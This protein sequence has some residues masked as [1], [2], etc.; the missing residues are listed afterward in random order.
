MIPPIPLVTLD[1]LLVVALL[2]VVRGVAD[3]VE[4]MIV[5]ILLVVMI[6]NGASFTI[7]ATTVMRTASI[8]LSN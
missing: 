1:P 7:T 3:L 4:V 2:E 8:T 5:L 6:L